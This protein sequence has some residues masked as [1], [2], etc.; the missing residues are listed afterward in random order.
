MATQATDLGDVVITT[1]AELGENKFT[2]LMS[3]YQ[4]TVALKRL[5]KK[6]KMNFQAGDE[7]QFNLITDHNNSARFVGLGETDIVDISNVMATGKIPW[8]HIT[9][10]WAMERRLVAMNRSPRKIVDLVKTQRI[11]A[12]G[13]AII[14]FESS[15]WKVPAADDNISPYGVPYHIVKSNSEG[16]NGTVPSG[17][18]TVSNLSPTTYARWRNWTAQYAAVTKDDLIRKWRKAAHYTDFMPLVD[19]IPQYNTGDD[20]GFYTNYAVLGTM[21]EILESQN[22]NLGTDVASMDGK[23]VFRRTPAMAVKELDLDTTNPIYGIN[24]GEFKTAGLTGEWMK[25]TVT[26]PVAGQH[27]MMATFTDC[28]FNFYCRNRRRMFVLA[29]N[30]GLPG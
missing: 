6:S 29:T 25:E 15:F 18:T 27:T 30:T 19:D 5:I 16:F 1:L 14:K 2:D 7:L 28:T 8:R 3:D 20:Y 22:E 9:W 17:Y 21:E 11:A 10:N 12:M 24:W 4:N 13:S 23:V 26:D